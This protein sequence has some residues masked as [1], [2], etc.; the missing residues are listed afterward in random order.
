M[1]HQSTRIQNENELDEFLEWLEDF[2]YGKLGLPKPDK[3][4]FLDVPVDVS[5][6]LAKERGELKNGQANDIIEA[7][8]DELYRA[9][10]RAKYVA[11]KFDWDVIDCVDNGLKSI[12]EIHNEILTKLNL[13]DIL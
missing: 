6:K 3:C 2:E 7:D 9:Y 1:I 13:N 12:E 11:K 10:S 4:V 8:K 5:F